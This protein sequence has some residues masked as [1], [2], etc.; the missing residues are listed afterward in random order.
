MSALILPKF[1]LKYSKW[2]DVKTFKKVELQNKWIKNNS[3]TYFLKENLNWI[4]YKNGVKID[5]YE[6]IPT[7]FNY[8]LMYSEKTKIYNILTSTDLFSGK[9][10]QNMKFIDE[11]KW[12]QTI[13]SLI[14]VENEKV[15][16]KWLN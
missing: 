12:D 16:N 3:E 15:K 7:E 13:D 11:G 6:E 2:M 1:L 5:S 14:F 4:E 8:V 9:N 10:L